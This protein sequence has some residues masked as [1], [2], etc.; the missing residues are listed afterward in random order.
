MPMNDTAQWIGLLT[1]LG[2]GLLIGVERERR[3]EREH[4][5]AAAGVRTFALIALAGAVATIIG[6][7]AVAV[8]AAFIALAALASY[9]RTQRQDPGLTTEV[10]ML[11]VYLLGVL[12]M[13][14][15]QL[16]GALGVVVALLLASKSRMHDFVRRVLTEAELHDGLLLAASA[17]VVL[18]LLPDR[19]L[20][21]WGVL[22]L[23]RIWTLVVIVMAINAVGYIALRALKPTV[24]LPLTGLVGGFVS[25]TAT[26]GGMGARARQIPEL[27][28]ACVSAGLMSNVATM[29]QI[30]IVLGALAPRALVQFALPLLAG[31]VVALLAAWWS[32]R[33][34]G[35]SLGAGAAQVKL[36]R[37]FEPAS[38][39]LFAALATAALLLAAGLRAAL[40]A[41]GTTLG[42]AAAGFADVHAATASVAQ[43]MI[44][45]QLDAQLA[46]Q[47]VFAALGTNGVSKLVVAAATGGRAYAWR[48]APGVVLMWLAFGAASLL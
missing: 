33:R 46:P 1:A 39:A 48:I 7:A 25:S 38:A 6:G 21:P 17:L 28:D 23:H 4:I 44:A 12:A 2:L 14:Q 5:D 27:R 40:G 15:A 26:I 37:P 16:A 9:R 35:A 13:R 19:A 24:G 42:V 34:A 3:K 20:D 41:T 18:P 29:V 31:T 32:R 30:A 45:N 22:N 11:L 8:A 10:A 47:I 43:L 36:G